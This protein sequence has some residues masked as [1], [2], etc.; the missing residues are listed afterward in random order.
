MVNITHIY[1]KHFES[2]DCDFA[3][4]YEGGGG[5]PSS[6]TFSVPI[7]SRLLRGAVNDLV[8]AAGISFAPFH[9]LIFN[10]FAA[11]PRPSFREKTSVVV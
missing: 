9:P 5:M 4:R 3:T 11:K 7:Y 6:A 1:R 8:T 10:P 2:S